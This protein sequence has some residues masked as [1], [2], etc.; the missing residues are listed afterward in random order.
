MKKRLSILVSVLVGLLLTFMAV[1]MISVASNPNQPAPYRF[2]VNDRVWY[3]SGDCPAVV[4]R[5]SNGVVLDDVRY[6]IEYS[7]RGYIYKRW[8]IEG[9][10][11]PLTNQVPIL[12]HC[13]ER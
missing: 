6:A 7:E 3:V 5:L 11:D 13:Y 4:Y 9:A 8:V 10:L 1:V 12:H 2:K